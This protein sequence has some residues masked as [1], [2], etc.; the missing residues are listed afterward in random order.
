VS[1]LL[2]FVGGGTFVIFLAI[3]IVVLLIAYLST[4]YKVAGADRKSVV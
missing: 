2:D 3:V 4:R 1:Q